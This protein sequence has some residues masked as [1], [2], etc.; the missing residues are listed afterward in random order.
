MARPAFVSSLALSRKICRWIFRNFTLIGRPANRT[1]AVQ[2]RQHGVDGARR[3]APVAQVAFPARGGLLGDGAPVQPAGKGR[4]VAAVFR[5]RPRRA[6]VCQ[7]GQAVGVDALCCDD[8]YSL[9]IP[10]ECSIN[11][12]LRWR[13]LPGICGRKNALWTRGS[14]IGRSVCCEV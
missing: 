6:L 7:K 8:C 9:L 4:Q 5:D 11:S 10:P 12:L 13:K 3:V 1:E 2:R 14:S